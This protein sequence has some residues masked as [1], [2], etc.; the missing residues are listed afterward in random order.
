MVNNL[1]K[2]G[3]Q[4]TAFNRSKAK[5]DALAAQGIHIADNPATLLEQCDVVVLMVSDDAAVSAI[6]T[7]QAGLLAAKASARVIINMSTVSPAISKQ[8]GAL[9]IANGNHYIDAPVSGSVKQATEAT[10]VIMAGG[11]V[12]AIEQVKPIFDALGKLTL[13][14]GDQGA[15]NAAKLAINTLLAFHAQGLAETI[16]FAREQGIAIADLM[17][18]INNSALGNVFMKIKGEAILADQYEAAF[19]LKHINKDL[20]L[21]KAEGLHTP[22][23]LQLAKHFQAANQK[24]AEADIIAIIK[25]LEQDQRNGKQA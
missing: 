7:D 19:A 12:D 11:A 9:C 8:M 4:V 10:L 21:A 16:I 22:L 18:L 13:R 15:G 1:I 20:N 24:L 3:Y 5:T 17:Q 25:H 23:A 2:A 14:V 6:F